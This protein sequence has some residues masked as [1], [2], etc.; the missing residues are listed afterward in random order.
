MHLSTGPERVIKE[1]SAVPR[2]QFPSNP[3]HMRPGFYV[4]LFVLAA[5]TL[6]AIFRIPPILDYPNHLARIFLLAGGLEQPFFSSA[7]AIDWSQARTNIGI[8]LLAYWLGPL[9]GPEVL[10]RS[11]LFVAIVLPP[12]GAIMLNRRL[13]G[14]DHPFHIAILF[15]AWS[16]TLIGGFINFQIG[17]GLAL[18]FALLD[19]R[20]GQ[21]RLLL[22][23]LWRAVACF[24]LTLDH[25]FAA[26]FY[27][28][29]S[30]GL[31]LPR[32][33]RDFADRRKLSA[34]AARIVLAGTVGLAPIVALVFSA[35]GLPGAGQ[36]TD[37]VWNTPL[38]ALS[39]LLSAITSYSTPLDVALF[40]PI[41]L[42]I[43]EA[44]SRQKIDVHFG[45]LIS[46]VFLFV[47]SLLAP[48]HAMGTGWISWRF[49]IMTLLAGA[50]AV[51]PFPDAHGPM[52]RWLVGA[53]ASAVFVRTLAVAVFWWQGDQDAT[54]VQRAIA[55]LPPNSNVLPLT[56]QQPHS[57]TWLNASRS[58]FWGQDTIRHL[59][60][61]ATSQRGAFV[62]TLFT[63]I[64]KQPLV[65]TDK[66]RDIS[67]PEG[68]LASVG[69]LLCESLRNV[70][71]PVAPYLADWRHRFDYVLVVNAE[72]PD[73]YVGS[74]IPDGL[75]ILS[76]AGFAVLYAVD[77]TTPVSPPGQNPQCPGPDALY[78]E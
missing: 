44:R 50:V 51:C 16:T 43:V 30:A 52:R 46:V 21:R 35:K 15:L 5:A 76:D 32:H 53:I 42:V 27:L 23:S 41:A 38:L 77:K 71:L 7:Y 4:A 26:G 68:N 20:V 57:M 10:S 39:N 18:L 59:P 40:I 29:L 47:L 1:Q 70:Y 34:A 33:S 78:D 14:K 22:I 24:V 48:R 45:L 36:E 19:L 56:R 28:V 6:V 63:A 67:V 9:I 37:L 58:F 31:E 74:A 25:V 13:F 3:L 73:R 72:Y 61:L 2:A 65:V 64:G 62:P 11:L 8:D 12:L 75:T 66:F 17:L 55:A 69:A 54:A 49:P 60:T